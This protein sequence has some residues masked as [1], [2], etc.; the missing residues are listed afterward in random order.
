MLVETLVQERTAKLELENRELT[1][2][3]D[4]AIELAEMK[5][6]F[7]S[8][9]SHDLRTPL[10]GIL[11]LSELLRE[12][13][14][15]EEQF[16]VADYI[17]QS[18]TQMSSLV[19]NLLDFSR[20]Q[21]GTLNLEC[22]GLSIPDVVNNT[23]MRMKDTV[24]GKPLTVK[25][26]IDPNIPEVVFGDRNRI[27]QV[28]AYLIDN[29][30]RF[31]EI[32]SVAIDVR[33]QQRNQDSVV[34]RFA[35]TDTGIGI[36]EV[37]REMLFSPFDHAHTSGARKHSGTGLGLSIS[38]KLISLMSGDIA[39]TSEEGRGSTFWFTIPFPTKLANVFFMPTEKP[40]S[41]A[42]VS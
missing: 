17:F 14:L 33:L 16:E 30:I 7:V 15:N 2:A 37:D 36:S 18:A 20:L 39:V 21:S 35:V 11:G 27:D 1:I 32:G 19:S 6:Q 3:R 34:V 4:R 25:A 10:A 26:N 38:N 24:K 12:M 22:S 5:T 31:T 9:V 28:L 8:T 13:G 40:E 23:V 42:R 29:A 41:A